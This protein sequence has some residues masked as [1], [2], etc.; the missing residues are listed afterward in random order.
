MDRSLT[1]GEIELARKVFKDSLDYARVRVHEGKY[2]FFQ[3]ETVLMTPNGE[4]YAPDKAYQADYSSAGILW[5]EFFIHELT[6]VWQYQTGVLS[7]RFHGLYE[8]VRNGF[9]YQKAYSYVLESG[10]DLIDYGMEQ[11]A[12]IVADYFTVAVS[13]NDFGSHNAN[14]ESF[15]RKKELLAEVLAKFIADPNYAR[16]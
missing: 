3:P 2:V 13:G 12:A 1:E 15:E 6:H 7:P 5:N 14:T 11:Q 8:F 10:R 16:S 9:D 4:I